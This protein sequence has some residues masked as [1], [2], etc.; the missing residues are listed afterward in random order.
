M[1]DRCT[2]L[3]SSMG[4]MCGAPCEGRYCE[5]HVGVVAVREAG[6]AL[7]AATE[8]VAASRDAVVEASRGLL[9]ACSSYSPR[10]AG[11]QKAVGSIIQA[12]SALVAA[13]RA[14]TEVRAKLEALR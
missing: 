8:A 12:T 14:E 10:Q 11:K 4:H 7:R 13:E 2:W 3:S 9:V 5:R 6:A 1:S